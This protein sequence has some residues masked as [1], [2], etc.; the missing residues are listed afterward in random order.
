MDTIDFVELQHGDLCYRI[1]FRSQGMGRNDARLE[2][3]AWYGGILAEIHT[4]ELRLEL[5]LQLELRRD[6][7]ADMTI[8]GFWIGLIR[9]QWKWQDGRFMCKEH[10][11]LHTL[12]P[13]LDP[14]KTLAQPIFLEKYSNVF[15]EHT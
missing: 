11:R 3:E 7:I 4:D 1:E 6:T 9:G 12:F 5:E 13:L 10:R 2:C 14:C 15:T 8:N